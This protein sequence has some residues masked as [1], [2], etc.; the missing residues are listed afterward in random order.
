MPNQIAVATAGTDP[1]LMLLL[2]ASFIA[3]IGLLIA[4]RITPPLRWAG[5]IGG[6]RLSFDFRKRQQ[7]E[8]AL[9]Q[10]ETFNRE[11]LEALPD[12]IIRMHRDGTYLSIQPTTALAS[13]GSD[14]RVGANIRR[15]LPPEAAEQY[16]TAIAAALQTGEMQVY[17]FPI[18][19]NRQQLWQEARIMP[20]EA[21]QV[22]IVVRDLTQRKQTEEALRQSEARL[23]MAQQVAQM[24]YWEFDVVQQTRRWSDVTFEHWGLDPTQPEPS[25]AEILQLVHPDDRAVV[26]AKVAATTATGEAYTLDLR[27]M[28]PDGSIR[29]LESR[30]EALLDAAGQVVKLVGTSMDITSRK[31]TEKALQERE[32]MLRAIGDNLPKGYIYQRVHEPGKG[33]YY[34]YVSA[35][36]ERLLGLKP[37]AVIADPTILR[38]VGFD[39]DLAAADRLIQESQKNFSVLELQMRNRTAAGKIQWSSIRS[40]PRLLEDGRTVWDGVEVD[41]TDLKRIETALRD[42]EEKFRKAF[43]DAPIGVSLVSPTGQFL[44]VNARY[45]DLVGY[46]EAELLTLT[47]QQI[48]HPADLK[49]DLEGLRQQIAGEI[50]SFQMEKRYITRQGAIVPVLLNTAPIRDQDGHLLYFVGHVQDIRDRL[51]VAQMKD[52]FISVVSHELRT[53]LTS[54]R[55]ALGILGTGVFDDRPEKAQ[56]MLQIAINNS[57]RLVR[58]VND[59]LSLERLESGKVQLV[60]ESCPVAD[61]MQQAVES[62]QAIADQSGITLSFTA[63]EVA[64]W[65]AHD[66]IIQTLTNLLGNAI[67]FSAPGDTVWLKAEISYHESKYERE[68]AGECE[69]PDQPVPAETRMHSAAAAL[70]FSVADQ[71]RGIPTD[72]LDLIFEQFQQVD[73]SDSRKRGGTGL[74][75]AICKSIVQ[76]HGGQIWVESCVGKGSTFYFT[77]PLSGNAHD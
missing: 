29:Y 35:G 18:S 58:L 61:L 13:G 47:F 50:L 63:L 28:Q 36:I 9:K 60:M 2:S 57:D 8:A 51:R 37:E 24:G 41:I 55:G 71:G 42:S 54:I 11:V 70:L 46:S 26:Q 69:H 49:A 5:E 3:A 62:V 74:G 45:C 73:H 17:E 10:S 31:Q 40:V 15:N 14:F 72:K 19:V 56:Q 77:L 30:A 6:Y 38:S 44:K 20:L 32:A 66:A 1:R 52:E 21:D 67:K 7:T 4:G 53:P 65:A 25:F 76:Q 23:A 39:E 64:I 59:I 43:D 33:F 68:Q 12:L 16:L 75:L 48:T 22:L 27:V 34:S